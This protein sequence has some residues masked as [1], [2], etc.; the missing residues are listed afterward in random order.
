MSRVHFLVFSYGY[1]SM[2]EKLT[3]SGFLY[4]MISEVI[5]NEN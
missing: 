5:K 2:K 1:L 4:A 3:V